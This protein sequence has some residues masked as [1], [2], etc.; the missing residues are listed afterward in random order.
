MLENFYPR[1][2][3]GGRLCVLCKGCHCQHISIHAL[4]EEG[5]APAVQ[6]CFSSC[7]FLSTP[8]A[9][10]ATDGRCRSAAAHN[11]FYPRPPRGGRLQGMTATDD[12]AVISI[13]AL[14]EE[15]DMQSYILQ[16]CA[17]NFYPRPPRGGRRIYDRVDLVV[18]A[19]LSTPSARRAT[20]K[21]RRRHP[22]R[23]DFYPRPPRGGRQYLLAGPPSPYKFLST[24]SARRATSPAPSTR[25]R[26][27]ISIHAL[28]EEGDYTRL[29]FIQARFYFYPRPPRGGRRERA[30]NPTAT[31]DFYP[32]PPRGGR[33][34]SKSTSWHTARFLSTPSARRATKPEE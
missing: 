10:R 13:H 4:R 2:P 33:P 19:F 1:P 29:N 12:G 8:S 27:D 23:W 30:H 24:P 22:A 20:P 16:A 17:E 11:D 26:R 31:Y 18:D 9:R 3:R 6:P 25:P 15:G 7:L 5:D 28:R 34:T 32:R 21:E 14:R